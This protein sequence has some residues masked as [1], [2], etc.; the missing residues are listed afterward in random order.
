MRFLFDDFD[1]LT[2]RA[3]CSQP[4]T[5]RQEV[6][7]RMVGGEQEPAHQAVDERQPDKRLIDQAV[8]P[9]K[10]LLEKQQHVDPASG[11]GRRDR[12]DWCEI[13]AWHHLPAECI[14]ESVVDG[15][16]VDL[17]AHDPAARFPSRRAETL[18]REHSGTTWPGGDGHSPV[19]TLGVAG[20]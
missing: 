4:L 1:G 19:H 13:D 5:G 3:G 9:E 2:K 18:R 11:R 8:G 15:T 10:L 20:H 14:T 12:H 7:V 6:T 16:P 17:E